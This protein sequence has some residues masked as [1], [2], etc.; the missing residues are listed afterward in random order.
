MQSDKI[1][2]RIRKL[3]A[4]AGD[5]SSPN[6]ATIAA[7]RARKLMDQYQVSE[8]DL[9]TD[10]DEDFGEAVQVQQQTWHGMLG[11]AMAW[12]NDCN[13]TTEAV[14]GTSI[15]LMKFQGYLVDAVT[16]KELWLYLMGQAEVQAKQVKG[17]KEP[18]KQGFA[19]GVQKQ[20]RDILAERN[21]L[22]MSDG[23]SL[24]VCKR[25]QVVERY[26]EMRTSS[27]R[28]PAGA[29]FAAGFER[30]SQVSLNRQVGGTSNKLLS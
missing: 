27:A 17:R 4:M 24:V 21:K 6:E 28:R 2:E 3:L 15:R 8:W 19:A 13:C 30:G 12:L 9:K 29:N 26:G 18:F 14:P 22:K 7:G 23:T 1:L 11:I 20:V 25:N 16:A 5:T 10:K